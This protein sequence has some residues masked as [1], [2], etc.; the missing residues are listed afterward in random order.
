[1]DNSAGWPADGDERVLDVVIVGG[2]VAGLAAASV[3]ADRELLVLDEAERLGGRL[4]SIPRA[5]GGWINLGAHVLTG[6]SSRI[7]ALVA[8]AGLDTLPVLGIGS[9]IWFGDRLYTRRRA[10]A[11]PVVLP[12]SARERIALARAGLRIRLLAALA[13][14]EPAASRRAVAGLPAPAR[15]LPVPPHVRR[16]AR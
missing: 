15:R 4:H 6:G 12:L 7:A 10:E 16:A 5:D 3:L 9:A 1:M 14:V 11:Y 2:G 8:E 13:A